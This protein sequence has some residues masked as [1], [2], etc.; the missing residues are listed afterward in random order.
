M[1]TLKALKDYVRDKASKMGITIDNGT[2]IDLY[3][4]QGGICLR[5]DN[6]KSALKN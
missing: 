5:D 1:S 2:D 3:S 6:W 4:A